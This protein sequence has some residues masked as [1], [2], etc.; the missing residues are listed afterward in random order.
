M[1]HRPW[2]RGTNHA[3]Q[4]G[5]RL[6]MDAVWRG[7]VRAATKAELL[8]ALAP[9]V[10]N[11]VE[12]RLARAYPRQLGDALNTVDEATQSFRRNLYE[13]GERLRAA[14]LRAVLIKA[15]LQ[16]DYVYDNFDLVVRPE[17]WTR[18]CAALEGWYVRRSTY[19]LERSTQ[20]LLEPPTGPSAHLHTGI[21]WFGVPVIDTTRLFDRAAPDAK[22]RCLIPHPAEQLRIW[23][24]HAVFQN[25]AFD[26]SEML[27]LRDLLSPDV[28]ADARGEAAR[29]GW[30]TGFDGALE[31]A[32]D[33]IRRLDCRLPVRLPVPLPSAISLV[34]GAEH[35]RH[36]LHHGRARTA[37][38]EATLRVPLVVAKKRRALVG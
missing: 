13:V 5:D 22:N 25:L 34:A 26:L 18:A 38:R 32:R 37:A 14:S 8:A 20:L 24:A 2:R 3:P 19:W 23:V 36:L 7:E 29:E 31:T 15:D 4:P 21:S 28:V 1:N 16:A 9:A 17:E 10:R 6:L 33:A 27:A 35:T 12:G 30:K 11:Q